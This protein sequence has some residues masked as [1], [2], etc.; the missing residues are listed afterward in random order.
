V[1]PGLRAMGMYSPP[2]KRVGLLLPQH[3][4]E[5]PATP[6]MRKAQLWT[7][8]GGE[9]GERRAFDP[10]SSAGKDT[11][12]FFFVEKKGK[13]ALCRGK[14]TARRRKR[15]IMGEAGEKV[16]V[17]LE[18]GK[19]RDRRYG[20]ENYF[21][22]HHAV[23]QEKDRSSSHGA[24]PLGGK[25]KEKKMIGYLFSSRAGKEGRRRKQGRDGGLR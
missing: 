21:P 10:V 9:G 17:R 8:M 20:G 4:K 2:S 7:E 24:L 15:G 5:R 3:M 23:T 12:D 25:K 22:H 11:A 13:G 14:R 1:L 6:G 19:G 18:K 16:A